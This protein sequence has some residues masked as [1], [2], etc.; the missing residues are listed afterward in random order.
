MT[1]RYSVF[2]AHV[3]KRREAL[4]KHLISLTGPALQP[5]IATVFISQTMS[6]WSKGMA[7]APGSVLTDLCIIQQLE[8]MPMAFHYVD[9]LVDIF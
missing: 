9:G 6:N 4:S 5:V 3:D 8:L 1:V 2:K 7:K